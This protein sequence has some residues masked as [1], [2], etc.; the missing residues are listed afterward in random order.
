M[1]E[2]EIFS[3]CNRICWFCP[4]SFI[5]RRQTN[6]ILPEEKYLKII[7]ELAEIDYSGY[8]T[9]SRYNEPTSKKDIFL[10]RLQQARQ[11][12]PKSKLKTNTNGDYITTSYIEDLYNSGLNELYIQQYDSNKE[13]FNHEKIHDLIKKKLE[14]IGLPF[15]KTTEIYNGR[16]EYSIEYKDMIIHLRARNFL[17]DGSSRGNTVPIGED[18][19]RTQRCLQPSQNMYIDYNGS[20]MICCA[21]RSD[22]GHHKDGIMGNIDDGFL[23]DIYYNSKYTP[24]RDHHKEDG[25]KQGVCRTCRDGVNP[26]YN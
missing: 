22:I 14:K 24:W 2:I 6:I 20:I 13:G 4:N 23:W 10:T 8:I 5:D 3:F 15:Q 9:Y 11:Q 7:A 21:L 16:I 19:V 12:L 1:I 18:Y 17:L 26:V 25:E